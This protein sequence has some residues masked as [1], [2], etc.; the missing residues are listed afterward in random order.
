MAYMHQAITYELCTE[1]GD[2]RHCVEA[3]TIG[4]RPGEWPQSLDVTKNFGNGMPLS[5]GEPEMRDGELM[6]VNYR[7]VGGLICL[8]VFND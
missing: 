1:L 2:F 6:A 5:R 8:R 4:L 3:S 7:Q